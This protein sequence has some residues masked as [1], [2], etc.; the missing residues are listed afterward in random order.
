MFFVLHINPPI[1]QGQTRYPFLVLEFSK[2]ELVEIEMGINEE[3]LKAQYGGKLEVHMKGVLYE[4]M[5]RLFRVIV[6]S[7]IIVPGNF[8]GASGTAAISCALRQSSGFLYPLEKGFVYVHKPPL[9]IRFEEIDN[10]H[11][12]RSD[13]STRSFDFEIMQKSGQS[14]I[15]SSVGKEEYNKLFDYVQSKGLKI[16]N[17]QRLGDVRYKE[18]KFADSSADEG[19]LDPYAEKLKKDAKQRGDRSASTDSEDEE[20]DVEK[21]IK[22]KTQ[23]DDSSAGSASEESGDY[24]E[25]SGSGGEVSDDLMETPE[26]KSKKDKSESKDKSKEKMKK[27]STHTSKSNEPSSSK[28]TKNVEKNSKKKRKKVKDPNA[29]KRNQTAFFLW[30]SDNRSKIKQ[31][32]DTVADTAVRAG[33]M[34]KSMGEDE[35]RPYEQKSKEDKERYE[36]EMRTYQTGGGG[37]KKDNTSTSKTTTSSPLK[38]SAISKEFVEESGDD[39]SD[40]SPPAKNNKKKEGSS[41]D[42]DD[43]D[44]SD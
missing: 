42:E 29:P 6:N 12:A 25:E 21:D 22:K 38:K 15:F 34:W 40:S 13:V 7:R 30:Q 14:V 44:D 2:D 35:K 1:R 36:R 39:S 3:Q 9:Y 11:F 28:S 19:E 20:Y 16:R 33:A 26:K 31:P 23:K 41:S 5:A 10:I 27:K 32:G 17:A 43:S 4:I 18:D 8:N 24:S 37:S